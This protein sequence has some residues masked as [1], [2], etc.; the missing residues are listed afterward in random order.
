MSGIQSIVDFEINFPR[1]FTNVEERAYGLLFNNTENP[2]SYDSN[3]AVILGGE[4]LDYII[5]DIEG[6]YSEKGLTPIIYS[7][8]ADGE[9][10]RL[11]PYLIKHGFTVNEKAGSLCLVHKNKSRIDTPRSLSFKRVFEIDDSI[12]S[13]LLNP[14]NAVRV[15]ILMKRRL[16]NER[17]HLLVGYLDDETPVTMASIEFNDDGIARI[18]NVLTGIDYRCRGYARQIT[19]FFVDY[20]YRHSSNTMYLFSEN[21]TAI[22]IYKEA[23]FVPL[24]H[25]FEDWSAR[26]E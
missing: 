24:E 20:H 14:E 12:V 6:F 15:T 8:L 21:P 11:K 26:K 10:V 9:L 2:T 5:R 13:I 22:K 3:H 17:F 25:Q 18:D 16:K 7:S 23:G 1:I 4:D 19:R